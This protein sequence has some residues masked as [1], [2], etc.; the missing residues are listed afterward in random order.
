MRDTTL[1]TPNHRTRWT[2]DELSYVERHYGQIPTK[3]I[4]DRLGRTVVAIRLTA[5]SLGISKTMKFWTEDEK[6]VIRTRYARGE[7]VTQVSKLLP[8]RKRKS[9]FVK[10]REMGVR[11][12]RL[13]SDEEIAILKQY[14]AGIGVKVSSLLPG[15]TVDSVKLKANILKLK[16]QGGIENGARQLVW[17]VEE[18]QLLKRHNNLTLSELMKIFPNRS[19]LSVKKARERLRKSL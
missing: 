16:Y 18:L 14:Y 11:S 1:G 19:R 10:A 2:L 17:S 9:I 13:W 5:K 6:H 4:A 3:A 7:G 12:A 15:R 8:D